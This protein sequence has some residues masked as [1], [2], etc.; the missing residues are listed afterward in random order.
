ML[1]YAKLKHLRDE[2]RVPEDIGSA[3]SFSE[4]TG[5]SGNLEETRGVRY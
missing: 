3:K 5:N 1:R 2:R 4:E